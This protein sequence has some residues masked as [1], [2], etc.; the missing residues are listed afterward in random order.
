M[1]TTFKIDGGR[2]LFDPINLATDGTKLGAEGRPRPVALARADVLGASRRST[3]RGCVRSFS[4]RTHSSWP[5]RRSSTA[6]FHLFKGELRPDG[7]SSSGRELKGTFRAPTMLVND[8]RFEDV[9]GSVR[10]LPR[11][12]QVHDATGRVYGGRANFGYSMMPLG[13]R[14]VRPTNRFDVTYTDVD[15]DRALRLLRAAGA[16]A[17]GPASGHDLIEWPSGRFG[18]RAWTVMFASIRPPAPR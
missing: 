7:T 6:C 15:L 10:W 11:S 3:C 2:I 16:A 1:D 5:A 4:R 17:C 12:L 14:G 9:A 18:E 8:Y 13:V